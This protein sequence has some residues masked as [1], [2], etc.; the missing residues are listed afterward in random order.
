M[1]G[2]IRSQQRAARIDKP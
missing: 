1:S 2:Q